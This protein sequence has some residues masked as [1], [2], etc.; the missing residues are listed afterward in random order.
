[1]SFLF[2]KL[3]WIFLLKYPTYHKLIRKHFSLWKNY[4][5]FLTLFKCLHIHLQHI[6]IQLLSVISR[7]ILILLAIT[8]QE[9]HLMELN[10]CWIGSSNLLKVGIHINFRAV[11]IAI[12]LL[13]W[14]YFPLRFECLLFMWLFYI[15]RWK[16]IK[17][18][19][20]F[21]LR[22]HVYWL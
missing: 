16:V 17:V 8:C 3:L 10:T 12:D 14:V 7:L 15:G 19:Q 11:G 20:F 22:L 5:I 9:E 21:A 1:M 2:V 4:L 13:M 18:S 6:S